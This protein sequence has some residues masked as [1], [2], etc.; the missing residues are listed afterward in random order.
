[1]DRTILQKGGISDEDCQRLEVALARY[2]RIKARPRHK[3][4]H[5]V[6][7]GIYNAGK[8]TLLNALT[9]T[10]QFPTGDIP[11]TKQTAQWTQEGVVYVDTPGLNAQSADDAVTEK[12]LKE[13][14]I[15]L[16]AAS[17]QNGGLSQSEAAWISDLQQDFGQRLQER[18]VFVMTKCGQMEQD[19]VQKV[20]KKYAEDF[21]KVLGFAPDVFATDAVIW[22]D[23]KQQSEPLLMETGGVDLLRS[24]LRQRCEAVC[25]TLSKDADADLTEAKR[26]VQSLIQQ[27]TEQCRKK[28]DSLPKPIDPAEIERLFTDAEKRVNSESGIPTFIDFRS[29]NMDA[30]HTFDCSDVKAGSASSAENQAEDQARRYAG[31]CYGQMFDFYSEGLDRAEK[32]FCNEGMNSPYFKVCDA[33]NQVLESLFSSLRKKGIPVE[34]PKEVSMDTSKAI[35]KV[36]SKLSSLRCDFL[37]P[38]IDHCCNFTAYRWME[39]K[40]GFFGSREVYSYVIDRSTISNVCGK[41]YNVIK[42]S[43]DKFQKK[44]ALGIASALQPFTDELCEKA[45]AQISAMR[46]AAKKYLLS[47]S[48]SARKPYEDAIAHLASLEVS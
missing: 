22:S 18:L 24:N 26:T 17:V 8:S 12:A 33:V 1:M 19:G 21:R 30:P 38:S 27:L 37:S 14:D 29:Y 42:D 45:T 20:A 28:R 43:V 39:I 4:P 10:E 40:Q 31:I 15:I 41:I 13:A 44:V 7:T 32:Q 5:V 35:S 2:Q 34:S 47:Q 3:E 36:S 23:G 9:G 25:K 11:T 48:D 16:F 6:C 46:E